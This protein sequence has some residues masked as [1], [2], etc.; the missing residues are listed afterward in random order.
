MSGRTC[1]DCKEYSEKYRECWCPIW[2]ID[3]RPVPTEPSNPACS[4]F[5]ASEKK[6]AFMELKE[7]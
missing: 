5:R 3:M 4:L 7:D 6:E 2:A 1:A